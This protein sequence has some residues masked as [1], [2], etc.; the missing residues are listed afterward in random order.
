MPL[1]FLDRD[2]DPQPA[3]A[4][5][6]VLRLIQELF[7]SKTKT[8]GNALLPLSVVLATCEASQG[9]LAPGDAHR[10]YISHEDELEPLAKEAFEL[11]SFEKLR[12]TGS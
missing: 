1:E 11:K 7:K 2:P 6:K 10:V 5:A 9:M 12:K 8:Q 4:N 3:E